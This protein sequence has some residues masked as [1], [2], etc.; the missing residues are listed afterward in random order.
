MA[1]H[2]ARRARWALSFVSLVCCLVAVIATGCGRS[3]LDDAL[4]RDGGA[5]GS[6]DASQ[7]SGDAGACGPDTC[8]TGCCDD[9][10]VCRAGSD[11]SA[12]GNFGKACMDCPTQGFDLCDVRAHS[13]GRTVVSCNPKTCPD[14]CCENGVCLNGADVNECGRGG[15][16]CQHCAA[17]GLSCDPI[18]RKCGGA[19]CGVGTCPGCCVADVCVSGADGTACGRG[20]TQCQNCVG[21]GTVCQPTPPNGGV[22][23]GVPNCGPQNCK[24]CCLGNLCLGGVD[25][26]ACGLA[27]QQCQNCSASG[28]TCQPAGPGGAGGWLRTVDPEQ[29]HVA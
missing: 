18:A 1:T 20:G 16:A 25:Q 23:E 21:Q 12:C 24:G 15:T 11:L 7:D 22:C 4:F 13:C 19:G 27:G 9:K 28:G 14:G 3:N 5:D 29:R 2:F 8:P 17:T 26:T 10:G 6:L